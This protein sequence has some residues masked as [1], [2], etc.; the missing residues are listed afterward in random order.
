MATRR[1]RTEPHR[2]FT[3][4]YPL[5][6]FAAGLRTVEQMNEDDVQTSS[7]DMHC[8]ILCCNVTLQWTGE[9]NMNFTFHPLSV[10]FLLC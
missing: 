5:T 4:V 10:G 6:A 7:L 8:N 2:L 9:L 3:P 1:T